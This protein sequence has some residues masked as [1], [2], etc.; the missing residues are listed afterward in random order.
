MVLQFDLVFSYWIFVWLLLFWARWI[1]FNPKWFLAAGLA[2]NVVLF[3][4]MLVYGTHWPSIVVFLAIN[5]CIK[6]L[7]LYYCWFKQ[8]QQWQH[9]VL[10]GAGLFV[11][12][13]GWLHFR[14]RNLPEVTRTI[15]RS[16]LRGENKTPVMA[17]LAQYLQQF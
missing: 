8:P 12:Y 17:L 7:P 13:I 14:R 1:P 5:T 9:D 6:A 10:F 11:V 15:Y 16:L 3:A 2:E 4:L